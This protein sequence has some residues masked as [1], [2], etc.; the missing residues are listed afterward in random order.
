MTEGIC[1]RPGAVVDEV[2]KRLKRMVYRI[3]SVH[4]VQSYNTSDILSGTNNPPGPLFSPPSSAALFPPLFYPN[5]RTFP[6]HPRKTKNSQPN[7]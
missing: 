4:H 6:M 1:N 7:S 3:S 2:Y 5:T